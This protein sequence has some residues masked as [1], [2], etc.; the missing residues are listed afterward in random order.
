[1]NDLYAC[2]LKLEQSGS[3]FNRAIKLLPREIENSVIILYA[4]C[5]E[6]DDLTD[7]DISPDIK[8]LKLQNIS[9]QN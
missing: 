3:S 6:L 4:I 2:K 9:A 5:R 1:M 7:S 8:L